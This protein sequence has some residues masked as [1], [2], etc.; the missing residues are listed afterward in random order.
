[1]KTQRIFFV[2]LLLAALL[3]PACKQEIE[4]KEVIRPVKAIRLGGEAMR[5]TGRTFPGKAK[6]TQETNL[7]FR[8]AGPLIKFPAQVGDEVKRGDV[9][10]RIDPRDYE[11]TLRNVQGQLSQAQA[12]LELATSDYDRVTRVAAKD[13]GAISAAMIDAKKGELDSAK[14]QVQSHRASVATARDNLKYTSLNA[15][16]DGTVVE[17]FVEN[18]ENVQAKQSIIRL[19]DTKEMEF[20]IS[21]PESLISEAKNVETVLVRFDAFPNLDIQA[22]IKE[23]GKEA[24]KTTRT[25][26]V[27]LIMDQPEGLQILPGMAGKA[28]ADKVSKELLEKASVGVTVPVASVFTENDKSYVWVVN[29][30]SMTVTRKEVSLGR[31]ANEGITILDGLEGGLLIVSAGANSLVEGQKIRLLEKP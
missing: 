31:V 9:L 1:M 11:V 12:L 29:E 19:V 13:P 7:A 14:A 15:P 25:Y 27:T 6:A 24:S 23:I 4:K 18:F 5:L 8:V 20:V 16:Y 28:W 26:P 30:D 21:I 3:L 2:P 22:T 17:T 10:A